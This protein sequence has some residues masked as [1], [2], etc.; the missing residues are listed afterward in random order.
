MLRS[1]AQYDEDN[2]LF[3]FATQG[4]CLQG[5]NEPTGS[6]FGCGAQVAIIDIFFRL[7]LPTPPHPSIT[8]YVKG[9][10][11]GRAFTDNGLKALLPKGVG[12]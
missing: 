10:V 8:Y 6:A 4:L 2:A 3:Q 7:P 5:S 12:Q 9:N 11:C 1:L